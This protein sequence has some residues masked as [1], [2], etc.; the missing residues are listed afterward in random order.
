[1]LSGDKPSN[2]TQ[3]KEVQEALYK[4]KDTLD[5][6]RRFYETVTTDLIRKN[7]RA[8]G[9]T[10]Q[11]D[12]VKERVPS[13]LPPL[14]PFP[15]PFFQYRPQNK[16]VVTNILRA[17]ET[18]SETSP[19]P[20]SSP[21]SSTSPSR[22]TATTTTTRPGATA[23]PST[24][25]TTPWR[26]S[27]STCSWTRTRR[28]RTSAA[29]SPPATRRPSPPSCAASSRASGRGPASSTC[30]WASCCRPAAAAP[31]RGRARGGQRVAS[32]FPAPAARWW[33][34]CWRARGPSRT[35]CGRSSLRRRRRRRR[36]HRLSVWPPFFSVSFPPLFFFPRHSSHPLFLHFYLPTY[37]KQKK[38]L[39]ADLKCPSHS[40]LS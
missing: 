15:F 12:I 32:P 28:A 33:R 38:Y 29:P 23:S 34:G 39:S 21:T 13:R 27:S 19:T 9:Q 30:S 1:M 17:C 11:I 4:P 5:D 40:G 24:R 10:Y 14:P 25:S 37:Q 3:R 20:S 8:L 7:R 35:W 16:A 6:V 26:T 31:G 36:R 22:T 18:A 2:A